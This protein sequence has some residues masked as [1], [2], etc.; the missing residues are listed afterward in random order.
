MWSPAIRST[1]VTHMPQH[2]IPSKFI[3]PGRQGCHRMSTLSAGIVGQRRSV[4]SERRTFSTRSSDQNQGRDF[5]S[6]AAMPN[7]SAKSTMPL[8]MG[9][10]AAATMNASPLV[11]FAMPSIDRGRTPVL[12]SIPHPDDKRQE[13]ID[14]FRAVHKVDSDLYEKLLVNHDESMYIKAEPLRH[15][16]IF[17]YGHT[18]VF[19]VNKLL[20]AQVKPD[21]IADPALRQLLAAHFPKYHS[22]GGKLESML[23]V[24]VD[25]MAW[26]DLNDK[27]Y[28]WPKFEEVTEY[29]EEVLGKVERL[30]EVMPIGNHIGWN[31]P[32]WTIM[33]GIEHANIHIETSSCIMRQLDLKYFSP[34]AK[35]GTMEGWGIHQSTM[36]SAEAR[37]QVVQNEFVEVPASR[38]V[39]GK[40]R[41]NAAVYGW[42]NEFGQHEVD[43][44]AFQ[45]S[46]YLASNAEYAEFVDAGGYDKREYWSDAGWEW[47]RYAQ[48]K[49][50]QFW[51]AQD[52]G[53]YML[54][55]THCETPLPWDWP[56]SGLRMH[57]AEAFVKWKSES[58]GEEVR[59]MTEDEWY[60][61]KHH[62]EGAGVD[63]PQWGQSPP[64]NINLE[65][66]VSPAPINMFEWGN[67]GIYDV[68]GNA[69]TPTLT[70]MYP[71]AGF[72]PHYV[73]DDFTAP[74]F[75]DLHFQIKG[76][77][78]FS[79]G[80]NGA[81]E[82][83]RYAFR[84]H[85][86][87][88]I[89]VRY[90]KST[91][92]TTVPTLGTETN[93]EYAA[94]LH[95]H[96]GVKQPVGMPNFYEAVVQ[97]LSAALDEVGVSKGRAL[98]LGCSAGRAS[99]ELAKDFDKVVG[100]HPTI[101]LPNLAI[102]LRKQGNLFYELASDG[103]ITIVEEAKLPVA[104]ETSEKCEFLQGDPANLEPAKLCE[105]GQFD[106]VFTNILQDVA[107]PV[108]MLNRLHEFVKPGGV[109]AIAS[110][111]QWKFKETESEVV[112]GFRDM[113][114]GE[115]TSS[116]EGIAAH[117]KAHFEPVGDVAQI[118]LAKWKSQKSFECTVPE[119]TL[120]KRK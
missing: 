33:M 92:D 53:S 105:D 32:W 66:F 99:F 10:S 5:S 38:V 85:F 74:C 21:Y 72:Q 118:P 22:E 24:G 9:T 71:Y 43:L 94:A 104:A 42:D 106:L 81:T 84:A 83:S 23:A 60:A 47:N 95:S 40:D 64:G 86:M 98:D 96:Y 116:A 120:W 6:A 70:P 51:R 62:P 31:D 48:L 89:G 1:S 2:L 37:S 110:D 87:Q 90:V 39:R 77:S 78:F 49:A 27:H 15:P 109:L 12:N 35:T 16:L 26:D 45:V 80:C 63:Q 55:L 103:D 115:T 11:D 111:H 52:D 68:V 112:G 108:T 30:M 14:Y 58:T 75:D 44:E 50:P 54:R 46:K 113:G 20:A 79:K 117:L 69:W 3:R 93:A 34:E 119:L 102:N 65:H 56:V 59:L 4:S 7:P 76:G 18:A 36:T 13:I 25:E 97:Q 8:N 107:T 67:S 19:Y 28:D 91:N 82:E 73:Y 114:T 101:N 88:E 100:V 41:S 17:Y 29:R 57:E 61:T